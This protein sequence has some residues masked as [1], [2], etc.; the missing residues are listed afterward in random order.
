MSASIEKRIEAKEQEVK[1]FPWG[2]PMRPAKQAQGVK[3]KR[4]LEE[5][6]HEQKTGKPITKIY[7]LREGLKQR[8]DGLREAIDDESKFKT[9]A[10]KKEYKTIL[11]VTHR[12][13]CS[14]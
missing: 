13:D 3:L 12:K 14:L 5:L 10:E 6:R 11:A 4:E 1:A 8:E 7:R 2:T 9:P